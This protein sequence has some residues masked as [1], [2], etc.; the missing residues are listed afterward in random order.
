MIPNPVR[1]SE[2]QADAQTQRLA[3][4]GFMLASVCH[5]LSNPLAAIHS[6][7][8]ILQSKRG[9]TPE[10]LEKGLASMSAN[11][12]RVLAITRKLGDFSRVGTDAPQPVPVD[13]AMEAAIW[14][15]HHSEQAPR[16][17]VDYRGVPG[18]QVLARSGQ[19][20]Q[21]F[22]NV[23]LNA[24]QAMHG[25]GRIAA[26]ISVGESISISIRDT[27]PGIAPEHL[28]RVFDP[29]FTTK[30]PGEGTGLGLAICYEIAHELG[31]SIRA[32]NAD[33]GGASFEITLPA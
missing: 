14:L 1:N 6:M 11:I 17:T 13:A 7:L 24:A 23:L 16:V 33:G 22:F 3:S 9:I 19:L 2:S 27:G 31:G 18:A 8:Q 32:A 30:A 26:G 10:T 12:G 25:S 4:L 21:I 15:L 20:E 5:E 29:F 28:E